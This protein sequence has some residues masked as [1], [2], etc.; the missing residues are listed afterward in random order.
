M[1]DIALSNVIIDS[2]DESDTATKSKTIPSTFEKPR[3]AASSQT[4][5]KTREATN[6]TSPLPHVIPETDEDFDA[7]PS[8]PHNIPFMSSDDNRNYTETNDPDIIATRRKRQRLATIHERLGHLSFGKLKMLARAG[9]I[10]RELANVDPPTCPGCAY[11]KATRRPKRTKGIRNRRQLKSAT[12]PGQVTSVD[13][14]ISPTPGL[15]P[16]HRG[17]PTQTRYVGATVFVDHFSDFTYVHLM[18]QLDGPSTVEAKSAFVSGCV[19][20]S[21]RIENKS[22]RQGL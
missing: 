9:I 17:K 4:P 13:P 16:T 11:G 8:K 20:G 5:T 18:T 2:D 21:Q 10:P 7:P 3:E 14:L 12:R 19:I 6:H 1:D 22:D 15:V